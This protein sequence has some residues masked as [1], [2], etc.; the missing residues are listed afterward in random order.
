MTG[1]SELRKQ[2]N[3]HQFTML[4]FHLK[5][6]SKW[7]RTIIPEIVAVLTKIKEIEVRMRHQNV[8][9]NFQIERP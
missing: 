1:I 4:L 9:L 8:P 5:F 3:L 2:L 6:C 7:V